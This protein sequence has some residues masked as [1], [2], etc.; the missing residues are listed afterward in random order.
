MNPPFAIP[1]VELVPAPWTSP[2]AVTYARQLMVDVGQSPITLNKEID[3]F[4]LNRLQFALLAEAYRLVEVHHY[5]HQRHS[6][7]VVTHADGYVM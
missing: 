1:L 4:A 5:N 2:S 7:L 6:L 3:G